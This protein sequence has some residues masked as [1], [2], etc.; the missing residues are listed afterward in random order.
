ME[1]KLKPETLIK[2][3]LCELEDETLVD[4]KALF[5]VKTLY[6]YDQKLGLEKALSLKAQGRNRVAINAF[7]LGIQSKSIENSMEM[8]DLDDY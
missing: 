1:D 4:S 7:L 5:I 3:L 6:R 2:E 8:I